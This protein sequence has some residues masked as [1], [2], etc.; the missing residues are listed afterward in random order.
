MLN[1]YSYLRDLIG[2]RFATLHA[3]ELTVNNATT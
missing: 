3:W 2:F 1:I